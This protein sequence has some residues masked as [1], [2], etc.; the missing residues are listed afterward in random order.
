MKLLL[1]LCLV[2]GLACPLFAQSPYLYAYSQ[3]LPTKTIYDMLA[4][5][6]GCIYLGTDRG[7]FRS[8][9][10]QAT[11]IPSPEARQTDITYLQ[12]DNMGR[13]WG[14]NF[15]RQLFYT[16]HDTLRVFPLKDQDIT[17]AIVS[18]AHTNNQIWVLSN[19]S[20]VSYD[21][22]TFRKL[23][24]YT[25]AGKDF[26]QITSFNNAIYIATE[27]QFMIFQENHTF[28]TE[29]TPTGFEVSF[30][31]Y[32][33]ELHAIQRREVKPPLKHASLR[34]R[35]KKQMRLPDMDLPTSVFVYQQVATKQQMWL[36]T[37]QGGYSLDPETGKTRLI[38]PYK[39][40]TDIVQDYQG[41]FWISTLDEGLWFCPS[42]QNVVYALPTQSERKI[43]LSSVYLFEGELYFGTNNGQILKTTL[44]N[45]TWQTLCKASHSEIR[46]IA[47][48]AQGRQFVAGL[49]L[50]DL[51][52]NKKND[53]AL[54]K[55]ACFGTYIQKAP[56]QNGEGFGVRLPLLFLSQPYG[57]YLY[58]LKDT[59][60]QKLGDFTKSTQGS[61]MSQ[62][63]VLATHLTKRSYSVISHP[64]KPIFWVGYDDGL[65]QYDLAGKPQTIETP[66][67]KPIIAHALAIDGQ[68]RLWVGTFQQG[69]FVFEGT[70]LIAHLQAGK[71][72]KNN[73]IY[74][75][76]AEKERMWLSTEA[77]IGYVDLKNWQY[78]DVLAQSGLSSSFDYKDFYPDEAGTWIAMPQSVMYISH[79]AQNK[80]LALRLLPIQAVGNHT[81]KIEALHYKNPLRVEIKYRLKGF[82]TEWQ[83]T[84]DAQALLRFNHLRKGNYIL[85]VYAQDAITKLK[86]NVQTYQFSV[87]ARWWETWWWYMIVLATVSALIFGLTYLFFERKRK[88]QLLKEQLWISQLK[89]LRAQMNPHFL[90]NILNTVQGLVYSNRKTEASELLGNFSD[91][92]RKSLQSSENAYISLREE[93]DILALY[94]LLEKARFDESFEYELAYPNI[95]S[96]MHLKIPSMLIQPFVENA[97]NHGLLHKKGA[98]NLRIHFDIKS[99]ANYHALTVMIDDNGIGRQASAEINQRFQKKSLGFS[100]RATN[101]RIKLLNLDQKNHI[102][103]HIHDKVQGTKVEIVIHIPIT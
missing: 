51:H 31:A 96:Y 40:M 16:K 50:F 3:N 83:T 97:I 73:H 2:C 92:M 17:G 14:M 55:D 22:K 59:A 5:R 30:S 78:T 56:R 45:S 80:Q 63:T 38:F 8:N 64:E 69:L 29:S 87:P 6:Q 102:A 35:E 27:Y 53:I 15:A 25:V 103:C 77:E 26:T 79:F 91:L 43:A 7:L 57:I 89:A 32:K 76:V 9:G 21:A 36:C 4:D 84:Q 60:T 19:K 62:H 34:W 24:D 44:P 71:E 42:L 86:S 85:E 100:T 54:M 46:R 94:L 67:K 48:D 93:L 41:S 12:E 33:G 49:G 99:E 58:L 70:K 11:L 66:D 72:L 13:L 101:Q 75:L 88:K 65:V 39:N 74:K 68:A 18:F 98:K 95:Q 82:D 10:K 1:C 81:F 23:F 90:Y 52:G 20:L 28:V 37:R 47:F 61:K